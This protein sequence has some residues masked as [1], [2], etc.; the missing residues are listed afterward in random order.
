MEM[1]A[2]TR[3][4]VHQFEEWVK[5]SKK[6]P[7]EAL[8]SV[9]IIEDAG[10]LADLIASHLNLTPETKQEVLELLEVHPRMERLFG[11]LT[12]EMEVLALERKIGSQVRRQIEKLQK[13]YYLREK[14]KAIQNELG[15]KDGRQA[16]ITAWQEKLKEGRYPEAV[17]KVIEKEIQRLEATGNYSAEGGVIRTYIDCL[18]ELPW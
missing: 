1:E 10:R 17:Q 4:V 11:L 13:E 5:L 14:V 3:S 9:A 18:M 16:E 12:R 2:L 8:V 6:I 15:D 7:P